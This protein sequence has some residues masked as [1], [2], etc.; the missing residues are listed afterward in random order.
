MAVGSHPD[1]V[2]FMMAGTLLRL[3]EAG[4]E[5]HMWNLANGCCG[6]TVH[7]REG[8]IRT[9]RREAEESARQAGATYHPPIADDMAIFYEPSLLARVAAVVRQVRPNILLVPS[10]EDYMEDHQNT[11]RLVVTAAFGRAMLNFV[12]QPQVEPWDG[13]A[14]V[15]HAM[16]YG[17]LDNLRRRVRPDL[18]VDV[19]PFADRKRSMLACHRSQKEWIDASQGIDAYLLEM[20]RMNREVGRMSGRFEQAEGWR[21]RLHL[22]FAHA[23]YNPLADLLGSACWTPPDAP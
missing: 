7:D 13:P 14:A 23:D 3:G 21:R 9:R 4:A 11:S 8:L 22:G 15:Y 12:T 16:P 6:T 19:T 20:E 5:I 1:D 17:L 18:Y 2:E 10:P